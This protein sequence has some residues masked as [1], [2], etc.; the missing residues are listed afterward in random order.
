MKDLARIYVSD[1]R[2]LVRG[3]AVRDLPRQWET[4]SPMGI[5]NITGLI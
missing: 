5:A 1:D 3:F 2:H 4:I